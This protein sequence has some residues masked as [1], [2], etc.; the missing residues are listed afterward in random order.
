M[1]R[2]RLYK[3]R[4]KKKKRKEKKEK[5]QICFNI[6]SIVTYLCVNGYHLV[7]KNIRKENNAYQKFPSHGKQC[8]FRG[9]FNVGVFK[10][11][12]I[13]YNASDLIIENR[14]KILNTRYNS[15]Y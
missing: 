4:P 9:H 11:C 12:Q 14:K 2:H 5:G 6:L 10:P 7:I 1:F 3:N 8:R 15:L 13:I